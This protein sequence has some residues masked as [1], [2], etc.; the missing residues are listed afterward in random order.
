MLMESTHR[1]RL[2]G[3]NGR[4]GVRNR[5]GDLLGSIGDGKENGLVKAKSRRATAAVDPAAD[6]REQQTDEERLAAEDWA[7]IERLQARNVESDPDEVLADATS[8]VEDVR[9]EMYEERQARRRH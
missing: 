1:R 7:A 9:Q 6:E 2:K 3:W 8:A 4:N 5:L